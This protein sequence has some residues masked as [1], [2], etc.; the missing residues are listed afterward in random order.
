[1]LSFNG[2]SGLA[3]LAMKWFTSIGSEAWLGGSTYT[4]RGPLYLLADF[5]PWPLQQ[6][7]EAKLLISVTLVRDQILA[8]IA[9]VH[10]SYILLDQVMI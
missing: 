10:M 3:P 4:I 2:Q 5:K 9:S 6:P 8:C 7:P 1:M